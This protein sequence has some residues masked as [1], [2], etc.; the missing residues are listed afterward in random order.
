MLKPNHTRKWLLA[1]TVLTSLVIGLPVMA[2]DAAPATQD[3]AAQDTTTPPAAAPAEDTGTEVVITGSRIRKSTF[4]SASPVQVIT[5]EKSSLSG[6]VNPAEV[7]QGASVANGAGQINSTFTGYIVGGGDG[8]NTL[9]LR[10]LGANRTLILIN[11]RRMPPAG[12]SG[13]VGPVDL[14]FIPQQVVSRYEIL[15][16][17]ASSIYGS[18]AVAG[19]VNIITDKNYDGFQIEA[20]DRMSEEKGADEYTLSAKWGKTFDKGSFLVSGQYYERQALRYSDRKALSCSRLLRTKP[21]GTS[22][23]RIDP[24]TGETKCY[25]PSGIF[26]GSVYDNITGDIFFYTPGLNQSGRLPGG[27]TQYDGT[28]AAYEYDNPPEALNTTAISPAKDFNLYAQGNY[29][30]DWLGGGELY[31]EA[32]FG[33]RKSS[34][35]AW[36]ELFPYYSNN[37]SVNILPDTIGYGPQQ[38]YAQPVVLHPSNSSQKVDLGRLLGGVR[39]DIGTWQ[40]DAYVSYSK[41]VGKYDDDVV[42][43]DRVNW[44]TGF[45]QNQFINID[46]CGAGAPAG[47]VPLN[48][49]SPDALLLGKLTPAEEAYYFTVD[50]GKTDYTQTTAEASLTGDI[51][52]LP[53]GALGGAFGISFREDKI[54]DTPG[55]LSLSGNSYNRTSSGETKGTDRLSEIYGELE[56]PLLKGHR[57]VEDLTVNLSGRVSDYKSVGTAYTYKAGFDWAVDDIFRVRG[58]AGTSFRAPALYELYLNDQTGYL[59]QTSVDPCIRYNQLGPDGDFKVNATIRAN[60]AADGVPGDYTGNNPSALITTGGGLDLKPETSYATTLGF[61]LTPPNTGF[62]FAMDFWKIKIS[63]QITSNGAAV[64]A[65]CYNSVQFRSQ[66]GF[67]DDFTRD[68]NSASPTYNG[69][70]TIDGSYRNI[71]TEASAGIDFTANYS[72]EFNYGKLTSDATFTYYK[73][74]KQQQYE[75]A[76]VINYTGTIGQQHWA[77]DI[78]T[79]F[80]HKDWTVAWTV[81]YVGNA[82]NIGFFGETGLTASGNSYVAEVPPFVTHDLSFRYR[83]KTF[84]VVAGARNILNKFAPTI[85]SGVASG[86]AGRIGEIPFSSQYTYSGLIGRQFFIDISKDF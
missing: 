4:N 10:G 17:G 16:D 85:G 25:N 26:Q 74:D 82:S 27:F 52:Q 37:S 36:G 54:D 51:M 76:D 50:H 7:L 77:G 63:D 66:P 58:T 18:D 73:Y 11:G 62:K 12:I 46:E 28:N 22:A 3:P 42:Y 2:Q 60:C 39:G 65:A 84:T 69:I 68:M 56:I 13:T 86:S 8:I 79:A 57:F 40:Y 5:A 24:R 33:E 75:G 41:S 72:H 38:I 45:D 59:N 19:V 29:R 81:N 44:G 47:C 9:S 30:P 35:T 31:T 67:C 80:Q 15:T 61:V 64:I 83:A 43:A 21:D 70:L 49:F 55:A 53:A 14:S 78:Q 32:M 20:T 34:Q 6:M 48:L 23:D 1:G 71:P